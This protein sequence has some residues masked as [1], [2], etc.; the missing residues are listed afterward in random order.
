MSL[1]KARIT[2]TYTYRYN[3]WTEHSVSM[4]RTATWARFTISKTYSVTRILLRKTTTKTNTVYQVKHTKPKQSCKSINFRKVK[5][6]PFHCMSTEHCTSVQRISTEDT[7]LKAS[8]AFHPLIIHTFKI[9]MFY[10]HGISWWILF[11]TFINS[12]FIHNTSLS[13]I[14][15]PI[16]FVYIICRFYVWLEAQFEWLLDILSALKITDE[17]V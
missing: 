13:I 4:E 9:L 3:D 12:S 15:P 7:Q 5:R 16:L 17:S 6:F 1:D 8:D 11:K 10:T 14:N 2:M